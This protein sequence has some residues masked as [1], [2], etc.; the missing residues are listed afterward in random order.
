MF[1]LVEEFFSIQGEGKYMGVPSYFLRTGGCNLNCPGFNTKYF[2]NS[3]EKRGCDTFFAVDSA[4]KNRWQKINDAKAFI[5]HLEAKLNELGFLP[6]FVITGGEPLLYFNDETFYQIITFL[7][8][9]NIKITIETNATIVIDFKKY[10]QYKELVFALSIKLSNSLEPKSKRINK[11]AIATIAKNAKEAFFKF[12]LSKELIQISALAEIKEITALA[13]N[14]PIY[15]M[16][17]GESKKA[18]WQND[19]AVFEFCKKHNF[20]YSDRLHIR[21][22]DTTQGV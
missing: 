18:L 5:T 22:F 2:I 6:H 4:F 20:Y 11:E 8:E 12:P 19:K 17:V 7:L 1:Y 13:P 15:C 3:K 9:K 16:P 21:V 10:P 14:L